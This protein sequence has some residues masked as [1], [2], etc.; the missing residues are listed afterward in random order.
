MTPE[1]IA[2]GESEYQRWLQSRLEATGALGDVFPFMVSRNVPQY[3]LRKLWP[4]IWDGFAA[5][6]GIVMFGAAEEG[7]R[8]RLDNLKARSGSPGDGDGVR[9][10][11]RKTY[12]MECESLLVL[13]RPADES[14]D[15]VLVWLPRARDEAGDA[16]ASDAPTWTRRTEPGL[17]MERSDGPPAHH[18]IVEGNLK[19]PLDHVLRVGR[20]TY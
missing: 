4:E 18:Y 16:R 11:F 6:P 17:S 8:G 5:S 15:V 9:V 10:S 3:L 14:D 19:V 1:L 2:M 7:W 20:R 13:T 12:V